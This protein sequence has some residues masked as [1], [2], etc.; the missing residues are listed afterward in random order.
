MAF[1]EQ[2]VA[3][4]SGVP[5]SGRAIAGN[6]LVSRPFNRMREMLTTHKKLPLELEKLRSVPL[7][8][9]ASPSGG[10]CLVQS[11]LHT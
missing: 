1:T 7:E 9:I 11:L 2:G 10:G 3:Q 8:R 5:N 6:I 4:L